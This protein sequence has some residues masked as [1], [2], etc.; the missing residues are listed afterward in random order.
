MP[1]ALS[2]VPALILVRLEPR[3]ECSSCELHR[4]VTVLIAADPWLSW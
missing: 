4:S 3:G 2:F 1:G